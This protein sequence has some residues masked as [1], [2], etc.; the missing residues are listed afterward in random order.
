[1]ND[2]GTGQVDVIPGASAGAIQPLPQA[3]ATTN[4]EEWIRWGVGSA[5]SDSGVMVTP[6]SA[7]R[8][9]PIWQ[10]INIIAG[11][12]GQLAF[13]VVRRDGEATRKDREHPL[14]RILSSEPNPYMTIDVFLETLVAWAVGWGNGIAAIK[15]DRRG[16]PE[17]LWPLLPDRTKYDQVSPGEYVIVTRL[18]SSNEWTA[19][20]PEDTLHVRCLTRNGFWGLSAVTECRNRIGH[21]MGLLSHGN[22]TFKNGSKLSGVLKMEGRLSP[23]ARQNLRQ[24]WSEIHQGTANAGK[25]A[26]LQEGL[27]WQQMGM[28]NNDAQFL[29]SVELDIL[30]AAGVLNLPPYKLGYLKDSAVRANLEAQQKEYFNSYLSRHANRIKNEMVRKLFTAQERDLGYS[31][32][33]ESDHLT[34]GTRRERVETVALAITSRLMT[35]NEG[36]ESLG[37]NPV[38]GGDQFSNPAIDTME[39]VSGAVENAIQ[40]RGIEPLLAIQY[41]K[42]EAASTKG[43][44]SFRRF[45][46]QFPDNFVAFG[47]EFLGPFVSLVPTVTGEQVD[48]ALAAHADKLRAGLLAVVDSAHQD[49]LKEAVRGHVEQSRPSQTKTLTESLTGASN[50]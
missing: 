9:S 38:D 34:Q 31:V 24:E 11:D 50:A 30:F 22:A 6:T 49:D 43:A 40:K 19:I 35:Q 4:P 13:D 29:E 41:K 33:V 1:M 47:R 37:L 5:S 39:S 44:E 17:S 15:R 20:Q 26:I 27:S 46:A 7:M 16:R 32:K 45:L 2:L 36:R 42:I 8:H 12:V 25:V 48:T 18:D 14:S 3:A 10:G 21:G 28:S 23:E